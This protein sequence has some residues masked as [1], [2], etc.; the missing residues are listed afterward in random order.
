M[1]YLPLSTLIS[2]W[3]IPTV[4]NEELLIDQCF[5][6][7]IPNFSLQQVTEPGKTL[8]EYVGED[9]L[10]DRFDCYKKCCDDEFQI[11]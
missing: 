1:L 6:E 4:Q 10:N 7:E 11:G 5:Y 3:L 8:K 9:W 2:L